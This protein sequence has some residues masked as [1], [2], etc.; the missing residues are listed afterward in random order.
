MAMRRL[1]A[2][3]GLGAGLMYLCDPNLGRRRRA[4]VLDQLEHLKHCAEDY[5]DSVQCD[6]SNRAAG[7]AAEARA[8]VRHDTPEDRVLVARVRSTLGRYSSHPRAIVVSAENGHVSLGGQVL[9]EEQGPLLKAVCSVRGVKHVEN[10]LE[11]YRQPAGVGSLQGGASCAGAQ[12][13]W[14]Q[15]DWNPAARATAQVAGLT[16]MGNAL[17]HRSLTSK[18]LG[19][20]GLGL[21]VRGSSNRSLV[22]LLG[23]Q[24]SSKPVRL[25]RTVLIHAPV[26]KVWDFLTD[27]EQVGRF[28]PIVKSVESLGDGHVRWGLQLPGGHELEI[29]ERVTQ[30]IPEERLSWESVSDYPVSYHGTLLLQSEA[31]DATRVHV[32]FDYAPPVGALGAAVASLCGLDAKSQFEAAVTR[33]KP[34]LETGNE[35]HDLHEVTTGRASGRAPLTRPPAEQQRVRDQAEATPP[36]PSDHPAEPDPNRPER[37]RSG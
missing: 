37:G 22:D 18:L 36:Q 29:E 17:V 21:L 6:L 10:F 30:C 13:S 27:F 11:V 3:M 1:L 9:A 2:G 4:L 31:E 33:I 16:L 8:M 7:V 14:V 23:L 19:I 34:F 5:V 26:E 25:Q 35:P 28:L 12:S 32:R 20:V 15:E 24:A